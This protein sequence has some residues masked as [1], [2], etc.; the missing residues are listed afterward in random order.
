[1]YQILYVNY[2]F[3]P[4]ALFKIVEY[5]FEYPLSGLSLIRPKSGGNLFG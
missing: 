4:D 1:M 2:I 5:V 3:S